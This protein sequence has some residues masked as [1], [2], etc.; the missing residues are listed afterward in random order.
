MKLVIEIEVSQRPERPFNGNE[1]TVVTRS[2]RIDTGNKEFEPQTIAKARYNTGLLMDIAEAVDKAISPLCRT[3]A[4]RL[5]VSHR[6]ERKDNLSF[7]SLRLWL[8]QNYKGEIPLLDLWD[9][10][11]EGLYENDINLRK[12]CIQSGNRGLFSSPQE[13]LEWIKTD[14]IPRSCQKV[15][16]T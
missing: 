7:Q 10:L 11:K 2:M 1:N 16:K 13:M 5:S 6:E 3:T 4:F 12:Y 9:W 15:G 14:A 8:L